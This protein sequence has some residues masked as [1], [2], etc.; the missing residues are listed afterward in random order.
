[1]GFGSELIGKTVAETGFSAEKG[2]TVIDVFREGLSLRNNLKAIVLKAGD[3]M[4]LRSPVSEMLTLKEAGNIALGAQAN[5]PAATEP[6][7]RSLAQSPA[8][9]RRHRCPWC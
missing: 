5:A 9:A 2:F 1:M 4:V 3:R 6:R 8:R 7:P